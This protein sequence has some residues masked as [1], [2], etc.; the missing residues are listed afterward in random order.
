M[1]D[2]NDNPLNDEDRK[3]AAKN[4]PGTPTPDGAPSSTCPSNDEDRKPAAKQNTPTPDGVPSTCAGLKRKR[5]NTR[6]GS[7]VSTS[8]QGIKLEPVIKTETVPAPETAH[9]T[10]T[11]QRKV[12]KRTDPLFIAPPPPPHNIVVPLST[13]RRSRRQIQLSPIQ[14]SAVQL[15]DSADLSGPVP[16]PPPP[17][18]ATVNVLIRRQSSR[19]VIPP[20]STATMDVSTSRR[21]RRQTK[22]PSIKTSEAL[23]N[24]DDDDGDDANAADRDLAGP[25]WEERLRELADYR[26]IHGD[27][28]VPHRYS[29]NIQLGKW[30]STQRWNYKMHREGK[31]SPMT[32]FRI[33]KL[34]SLSF[35]WDCSGPSWEDTFSEL[36]DYH[37]IH[38]HCNPQRDSENTKLRCWIKTQK[39][40]Y[41][42]Y[43]DGKTSPM[44]TLRIQTL[45]SLGFEWDTRG[46]L[47]EARL[48]ELVGYRK[49]HGHCNIPHSYSKNIKLGRWVCNQRKQ[50]TL[51]AQGN[52]SYIMT[53]FRIQKLESLGFEWD[54]S[55][56]QGKGF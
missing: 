56:S 35:E 36:A 33:Q 6:T 28:N 54:R 52:K 49:I 12:A 22:L 29:E 13:R 14:T 20:T 2:T 1:S 8:G 55:I 30:V 42:L 5:T 18:P 15:D 41:L 53:S 43:R 4:T 26:K 24:D 32:P 9:Q 11:V 7:V 34:E 48:S 50:Y 51:H 38:G 45:E 37:R 21:S 17:P 39:R 47:W 40:S 23:L 10:V 44:T 19:R 46:A 16:P 25:S 27:S 3:P 31:T